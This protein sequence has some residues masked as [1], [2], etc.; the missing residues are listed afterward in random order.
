MAD[1]EVRPVSDD[2][3]LMALREMALEK[4]DPRFQCTPATPHPT[5]AEMRRAHRV[6][7]AYLDGDPVAFVLC[8]ERRMFWMVGQPEHL[9]A[10]CVSLS[11]VIHHEFAPAWGRIKNA[12]LRS[13]IADSSGG[14]IEDDGTGCRWIGD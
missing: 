14:M 12:R 2:A 5:I 7:G 4:C 10:A 6:Y 1:Y 13:A 11:N 3:D 9:P 8:S